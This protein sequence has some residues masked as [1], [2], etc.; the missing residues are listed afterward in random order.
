M[1]LIKYI[2]EFIK[3]SSGSLYFHAVNPL[4]WANKAL[5]EPTKVIFILPR[6]PINIINTFRQLLFFKI[7]YITHQNLHAPIIT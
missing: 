7:Y 4:L 3:Y 2:I 6:C 5:P 1:P